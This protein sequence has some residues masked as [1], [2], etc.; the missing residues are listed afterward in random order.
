MVGGEVGF[1]RTWIQVLEY[2]ELVVEEEV[3]HPPQ[4][5]LSHEHVQRDGQPAG[6]EEGSCS[7]A[8]RRLATVGVTLRE[9]GE[10][11]AKGNVRQ[12]AARPEGQHVFAPTGQTRFADEPRSLLKLEVLDRLPTDPKAV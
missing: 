9:G 11:L 2:G 1:Q 6:G 4:V 8:A 7:Q 10:A 5:H 12:Y 3:F